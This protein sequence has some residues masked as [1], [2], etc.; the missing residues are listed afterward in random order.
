MAEIL[1]I[2][3]NPLSP[4]STDP[5]TFVWCG[6]GRFTPFYAMFHSRHCLVYP[7]VLIANYVKPEDTRYPI[8]LNPLPQLQQPLPFT[9][10][11]VPP[12]VLQISWTR[13]R[14]DAIL[15]TSTPP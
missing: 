1:P 13:R 8:P 15:D 9:Y 3:T 6:G 10:E 5:G 14:L 11:F 2:F 7:L 12:L 4:Y